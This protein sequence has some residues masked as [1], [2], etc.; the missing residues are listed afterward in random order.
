MADKLKIYACS[1]IGENASQIRYY[2]DGNTV[3]NT[4]AVNSL[5]ADLNACFVRAT[6]L[7]GISREQKIDY[8]NDCD[9]LSV[10]IHAAKE[11]ADTQEHLQRAGEAIGFMCANGYFEYNESD[12]EKRA[13]NLETLIA[14]FN[15]LYRDEQPLEPNPE[16]ADW[17]NKKV[18]ARNK[19]GLTFDRQMAI[20]K[21]IKNET[22]KI[23]KAAKAV[24]GISGGFAD[25][26]EEDKDLSE[27]LTNAGSY[28]LY[29]FLTDAQL[30]KLPAVFKSKKRKQMEIYNACQENFVGVYGSKKELDEIIRTGIVAEFETEP[31]ELAKQIASGKS[32]KGVGFVFLGLT[33]AEAVTALITLI[34]TIASVLVAIVKAIC[35]CVRQGNEAKYSKLNEEM[36]KTSVFDPEDYENINYDSLNSGNK[37]VVPAII[38]AGL[39]LIL[40][41]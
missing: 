3:S 30:A 26:W 32:V 10:C 38:G 12:N 19:V 41:R 6:R 28:F 31:E 16:F 25:T 11:C 20:R 2:V 5:L 22:P 33:G 4:Q 7:Q 35:D 18:M 17:W 34:S 8:L 37:W 39:L 23:V 24:K 27:Y 36:V 9:M 40:K 1:G 15:E 13:D 14:R 21:V 29:T